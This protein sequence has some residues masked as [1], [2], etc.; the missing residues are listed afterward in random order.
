M[1][2]VHSDNIGRHVIFAG[3]RD[4]NSF[5][6]S[7]Q[8]LFCIVDMGKTTCRFDYIVDMVFLP[9]EL[10]WVFFCGDFD[11]LS[12]DDESIDRKSVV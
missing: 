11:P 2:M 12:V 3:S 7:C 4:Q 5:G 1:C 6:T 9:R 10:F 8:M